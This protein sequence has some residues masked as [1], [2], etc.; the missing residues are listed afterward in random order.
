MMTQDQWTAVDGYIGES[1]LGSDPVLDGVLDAAAAAGLPAIAVSPSQGRFLSIMARAIGATRILEL[2]TLGGYSGIWL[3]RGL[4]PGGQLVTVEV[5]PKHADV[6]RRSFERA[7]V[8]GV[9]DLRIGPALDVLPQLAAEGAAPFDLVFI[10]ADKVHYREYFDWAVRLCRPGALIIA[11]NVV[12]NGAVVD[13]TS[14]DTA[15]RGVR[16][17]MDRL[18][19]DGRVTATAI[20]TVGAKGYDGFAVALVR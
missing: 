5:D 7:G 17:L 14:N 19:A 4:P 13:A 3:A 20:Q 9:I 12:R 11:D 10:D 2:G 6:A 8:S 15:V 18:G 16:R 1:L